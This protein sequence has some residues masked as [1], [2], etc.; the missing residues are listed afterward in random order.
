VDYIV[1]FVTV[2]LNYNN[3]F[4]WYSIVWLSIHKVSVL[5]TSVI[6]CYV[7]SGFAF[8]KPMVFASWVTVSIDGIAISRAEYRFGY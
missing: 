1:F 7:L 3:W 2:E 5:V 4:G 8:L 6:A